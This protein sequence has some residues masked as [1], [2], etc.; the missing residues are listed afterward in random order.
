MTI[1]DE[2]GITAPPLTISRTDDRVRVTWPMWAGYSYEAEVH[3]DLGIVPLHDF[4]SPLLLSP[5]TQAVRIRVG[6]PSAAYWDWSEWGPWVSTTQP[7][8]HKDIQNATE[9]ISNGSRWLHGQ[10]RNCT[11]WVILDAQTGVLLPP[12]SP[13]PIPPAVVEPTPP[14]PK[15]LP[16]V[17]AVTGLQVVGTYG[18]WFVCWDV[19]PDQDQVRYWVQ[20]DTYQGWDMV[21]HTD[22]RFPPFRIQDSSGRVRVQ[23]EVE[24]RISEWSAWVP[25]G[26]LPPVPE[27][28][29]PAAAETKPEV[30]EATKAR[31]RITREQLSVKAKTYTFGRMLHIRWPATECP[32]TIQQ[33]QSDTSE[34][35]FSFQVFEPWTD[36]ATDPLR[37]L[38][39]LAHN[40]DWSD[41]FSLDDLD[42]DRTGAPDD[43]EMVEVAIP[44]TARRYIVTRDTGSLYASVRHPSAKEAMTEAERLARKEQ[45]SFLVWALV[46]E[47]TVA[48][49]P[50]AW[51]LAQAN[52]D[53]TMVE[54]SEKDVPF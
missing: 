36:I 33:K 29:T 51:K 49:A 37:C 7:C 11:A 42:P 13:A 21:S 43:D 28:P 27:P 14:A 54:L 23:R 46:G 53:P 6:R 40:G 19:A 41:W 34:Y 9:F 35:V 45:A 12:L 32:Y 3:T 48:P 16:A 38:R 18:K 47:C 31:P 5:N 24:Y 8:Q 30:A 22:V 44:T 25:F 20:V 4:T 1:S 15:A 50:V 2:Q 10:C 39:I 17:P 26:A 52:G